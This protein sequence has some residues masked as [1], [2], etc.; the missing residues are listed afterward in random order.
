MCRLQGRKRE[1]ARARLVAAGPGTIETGLAGVMCVDGAMVVV[2]V[3]RMAFAG[4]P[5]PTRGGEEIVEVDVA[6]FAA[7]VAVDA[8]ARARHQHGD[9]EN[10]E[11][12]EGDRGEARAQR[13]HFIPSLP[14]IRIGRSARI[15]RRS[16][17]RGC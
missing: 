16:R 8:N 11:R 1:R 5:V 6:R 2:V 15:C 3:R 13:P 7:G 12:P 17:G 10:D 9:T 4:V 14:A